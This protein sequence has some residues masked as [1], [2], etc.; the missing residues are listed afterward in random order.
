MR[1]LTAD[2]QQLSITFSPHSCN[3]EA[4]SMRAKAM[5]A[6]SKQLSSA[7][8]TDFLDV[9]VGVHG[10]ILLVAVAVSGRMIMQQS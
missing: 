8:P 3:R 7:T 4:L 9:F 6:E 5:D 1:F 2:S 10:V